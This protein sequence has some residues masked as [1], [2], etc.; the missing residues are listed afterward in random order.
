MSSQ[1]ELSSL[2]GSSFDESDHTVQ[3]IFN[4]YDADKDSKLNKNELGAFLQDLF[5]DSLSQPQVDEILQ[6]I[7]REL[8]LHAFSGLWKK[9]A[10]DVLNPET[11]FLIVDVQNDFISGSLALKNCPAGEDGAEVVQPINGLLDTKLFKHVFV[12][13]DWHPSDHISF[14]SNVKRYQD[15]EK[16]KL[17]E[18][19][20][21]NDIASLKVMS[22]VKWQVTL[23]KFDKPITL[24]QTLWPDHCVQ[25][26][27]GAKLHPDLKVDE[28]IVPK[29]NRIYK[30]SNK[31][32]DSY[33]AFWDN[34]EV[35]ETELQPK[36]QAKGVTDIYVCGLATDV[37][38]YFTARHACKQGY[39]VIL[40]ED[41]CRGVDKGSIEKAKKDLLELGAI[42][43]Q[44]NDVPALL[45]G[46]TR[47]AALGLVAAKSYKNSLLK[48]Q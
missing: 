19:T 40:V 31:L 34:G 41:L 38:V 26:T 1:F 22:N 3:K 6:L 7:A 9:L 24:D 27:E 15:T 2:V 30:G 47:P 23:D 16:T 42:I 12:S 18:P 25:N 20:N 45:T 8:D 32:I 35:Q 10:R 4:K 37:C 21:P 36:L 17:V 46:K 5:T 48:K 28:N 11:C 43:V 33:S 29:E 13:I 39:R 44:S 14:A